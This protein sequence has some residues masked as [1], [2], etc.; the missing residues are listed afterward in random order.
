[1]FVQSFANISNEMITQDCKKINVLL[2]LDN[3]II[4][5]LDIDE[6][7]YINET[8]Q[9]HFE[10]NDMNNSKG[11]V[12]YR[13]F[14]RPHLQTFLDF[15]FQNFNVSIWTAA[16]SDYA[17]F[18]VDKFIKKNNPNRKINM[19]MY[20]YHVTMAESKYGEGRIKDLNFIWEYL[21]EYNY[22]PCNTLIVDDL[23]DVQLTN[24]LNTIRLHPF[25]MLTD[26][27][28]NLEA[29]SDNTLIKIINFL[30]KVKENYEQYGCGLYI[31]N[32]AQ[33]YVPI[34][35]KQLFIE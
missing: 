15:L 22:Y 26:D 5:A 28:I 10:F 30:T 7:K 19:I 6:L 25:D 9:S 11:E 18:I 27:G 24:P 23:P 14:A 2:D 1:M 13:V 20:R 4:N 35:K 8:Y 32:I 29:L 16:E 34:L 3:T 33:L 12:E 17:L 21:K 31:K